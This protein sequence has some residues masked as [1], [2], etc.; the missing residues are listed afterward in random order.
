ME[1]LALSVTEA[2]ALMDLGRDKVYDLI[3]DG[4]LPSFKIGKRRLVPASAVRDFVERLTAQPV[5]TE[6]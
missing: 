5:A 3:N 2:G 4:S 1:K 6:R